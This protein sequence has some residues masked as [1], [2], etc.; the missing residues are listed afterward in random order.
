MGKSYNC[1]LRLLVLR[2]TQ[3]GFKV[4]T[5]EAAEACFLELGYLRFGFD[6]EVL[7]RARLNWDQGYRGGGRLAQC[8]WHESQFPDGRRSD[9]D[10]PL[11]GAPSVESLPCRRNDLD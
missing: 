6:A 9:A 4:F 11:A 2:Y 7:L 10:R 1:L 3:C 8:A 5:A